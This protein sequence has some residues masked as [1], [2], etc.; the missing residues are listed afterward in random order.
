[1]VVVGAK[2]QP[3]YCNDPPDNAPGHDRAS[4]LVQHEHA[5]SCSLMR[6]AGLDEH[7][8]DGPRHAAVRYASKL[9]LIQKKPGIATSRALPAQPG[10]ALSELARRAIRPKPRLCRASAPR[11]ARRPGTRTRRRSPARVAAGLMLTE[12]RIGRY[13]SRPPAANAVNPGTLPHSGRV[14]RGVSA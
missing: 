10:I 3:K 12:D 8:L 14:G 11:P 2:D 5:A 7:C 9:S 1:M 4:C 6:L 13:L